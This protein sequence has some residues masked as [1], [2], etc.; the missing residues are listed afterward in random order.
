MDDP[1]EREKILKIRG[2]KIENNNG[3]LVF[4]ENYLVEERVWDDKMYF[5]PIPNAEIMKSNGSL[6]QNNGW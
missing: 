5:Y 4:D 1:I 2:M 6:I 3:T